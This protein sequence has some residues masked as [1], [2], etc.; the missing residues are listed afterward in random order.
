MPVEFAG[1]AGV[2]RDVSESGVF[3]ET[4]MPVEMGQALEFQLVFGDADPQFQARV[5]CEGEVVRV[6][7]LAVG[8]GVAVKLRAYRL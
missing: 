1:G 5:H 3:F 2:T 4:V 8:R 6:E 7:P